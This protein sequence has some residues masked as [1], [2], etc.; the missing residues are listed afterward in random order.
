MQEQN[1]KMEYLYVATSK[2]YAR[3]GL[4]KIGSTKNLIKRMRC[5]QTGRSKNDEMFYC[6]W[7]KCYNSAKLDARIKVK[8]G[9]FR[10]Q[11]KQEMYIFIFKDLVRLL[12]YICDIE[13]ALDAKLFDYKFHHRPHAINENLPYP[14]KVDPELSPDD[15]IM[16]HLIIVTKIRTVVTRK[17]L[18]SI[19]PR[20][21]EAWDRIKQ[22]IDW[23]NS[24]TPVVINGRQLFV[25]Y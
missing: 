19:Y 7:R 4:F 15:K 22:L 18:T 6:W 12:E 25:T 5:Y 13:D 21:L 9:E 24:K 10:E 23:K 11:G 17:E 8:L 3:Q 20:K 2:A 1:A 14:F 16:K